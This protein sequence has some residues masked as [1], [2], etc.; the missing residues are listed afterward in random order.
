MKKILLFLSLVFVFTGCSSKK[1]KHANI[2]YDT[3]DTQIIY[4]EYTKTEKEYEENYNFVKDE[5]T[6]LHK[7][8]DNYRSY[9]GINNISTVNEKAGKE[10]VVVDKDLFDL[11]K[12]SIDNYEKSLGYTNIAMGSVLDIWH[13]V[14]E[15]NKEL[16]ES[17]RILPDRADLE[18]ADKHTDIN[19]IVLNEEDS[20]IYIKDP[21]TQ[22][23][24]GS[25][26]KGYAVE[27]IAQKLEEKGVENGS[28]N[29]G[30]NVRTIGKPGD[31]RETWGVALQNPNMEAKGFLDVLYIEG[32][33]SVVT[34]GDYQRF[35]TYKGKNYHHLINPYEL[36]PTENYRAVTVVT[37]D[38]GLADLLSTAFFLAK[39]EEYDKLIEN[40][41]DQDIGLIW[42]NETIEKNTD[43]MDE[44]M[45][46][47]GAKSR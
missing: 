43:N 39:P 31:G 36:E 23:D 42:A 34:S 18:E 12:F 15:K 6:R 10:A 14:R 22:I 26:A 20:S 21:K 28:I 30:G 1:E 33:K 13:D 8:Y 17:E 24:L 46:S 25:V 47:K 27:L 5:F 41:K 3:F 40:Y 29:A 45:A 4:L 11:V 19:N 37:K 2:F 7:L 38:S 32:S 35:F 9:K 44:I 16:E